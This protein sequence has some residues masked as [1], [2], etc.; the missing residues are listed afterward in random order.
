MAQLKMLVILADIFGIPFYLLGMWE[1][2]DNG[3]GIILS[4]LGA[5]YIILRMYYYNIDRHQRR[6]ERDIEIWYKEE[7][8]RKDGW[9][10][11]K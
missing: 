7:Q 8:A 6:R 3:R 1:N 4:I 11:K 9:K 5:M 2:I 10:P